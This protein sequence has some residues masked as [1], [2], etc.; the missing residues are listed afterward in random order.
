MNFISRYNWEQHRGRGGQHRT[1]D[2]RT[3]Q[4]GSIPSQVPQENVHP[5]PHRNRCRYHPDHNHRQLAEEVTTWSHHNFS[6]FYT[7]ILA[8]VVRP[9][10]KRIINMTF[11]NGCQTMTFENDCQIIQHLK[12]IVKIWHLIMTVKFDIFWTWWSLER[13]TFG[14]VL[15]SRI[16]GT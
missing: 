1:G 12:T 3:G 10:G 16:L 7:I 13:S 4:G 14:N 5:S 6:P 8:K 2:R 9:S 11:E 15:I